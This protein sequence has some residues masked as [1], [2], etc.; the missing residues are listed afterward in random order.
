MQYGNPI[1]TVKPTYALT[2]QKRYTPIEYKLMLLISLVV[3][4]C[5]CY[6]HHH[7]ED[8]KA[9]NDFIC[10]IASPLARIFQCVPTTAM[11]M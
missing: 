10:H 3:K 9:R 11:D 4:D 5:K 8:G 1:P 6:G 7:W 2:N